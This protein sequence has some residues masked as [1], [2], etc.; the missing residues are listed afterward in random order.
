MSRQ[1]RSTPNISTA[2]VILRSI[3]WACITAAVSIGIIGKVTFNCFWLCVTGPPRRVCSVCLSLICSSAFQ[4]IFALPLWRFAPLQN[5]TRNNHWFW[6][7][8]QK[9]HDHEKLCYL[10]N[11]GEF[12]RP[13]LKDRRPER[14]H[15][16]EERIV[17]MPS[18]HWR[19]THCQSQSTPTAS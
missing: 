10:A 11:V 12:R 6:C 19:W 13:V 14:L 8:V 4:C 5:L 2:T 1:A 3:V 15:S 16:I 17:W 18:I 7:S 9:A